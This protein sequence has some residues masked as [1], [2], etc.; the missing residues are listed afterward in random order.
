MAIPMGQL[1]TPS[2]VA[3]SGVSL[4]GAKV[5]FTTA[6]S[7]NIN[8]VFDSTYDNYL[9][10]IRNLGNT[11]ISVDARLRLAGSDASTT[12]YTRQVLDAYGT[13][14]SGTRDTSQ[15]WARLM[16]ARSTQNGGAHIYIYGP[17]LAQPTA[18]RSVTIDPQSAGVAIADNACT[19]SVSTA[20]DG[21]TLFVQ[22]ADTTTGALTIYGLSQ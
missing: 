5:V 6:N 21:I 19:H 2:S 22:G 20:Y 13:T 11:N 12:A 16:N 14:V 10:V 8:G 7:I 4:S 9:I 18:F 3:G 17:A 15:T 1:I